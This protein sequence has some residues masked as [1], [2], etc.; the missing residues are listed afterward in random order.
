MTLVF[1]KA[2]TA[3]AIHE[4]VRARRTAVYQAQ[5]LW[6]DEEFLSPLFHASTLVCQPIVEIDPDSGRGFLSVEN[7]SDIPFILQDLQTDA[8]CEWPASIVL[9]PRK[10]TRIPVSIL[11]GQVVECWQTQLD[12]QVAN[13]QIGPLKP[14]RSGWD[15]L[16][17]FQPRPTEVK[18]MVSHAPKYS[19]LKKNVT[20][21]DAPWLTGLVSPLVFGGMAILLIVMGT[22]PWAFYTINGWVS[23]T[24]SQVWSHLTILGDAMLAAVFLLFW[25]RKHPEVFWTAV[26]AALLTAVLIRFLKLEFNMPR[27][28]HCLIK[29]LSMLSGLCSSGIPCPRAIPLRY[30]PS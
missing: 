7:L 13:C 14:L 27:P 20:C 5:A 19:A 23:V 30:L 3:E 26:V 8:R 4:A 17:Q 24:G 22:N 2:R 16:I 11:A 12:F 18:N 1:A 15:V 21:P 10:T 29:R 25:I 6:G 28:Q 9:A